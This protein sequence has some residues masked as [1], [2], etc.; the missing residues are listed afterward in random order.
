MHPVGC[1]YYLH[2]RCTVKQISDN[3]IYLLIKH[4]KS[5]LWRV[6]KRLSYREDARCLKIKAVTASQLPAQLSVGPDERCRTQNLFK[7]LLTSC[8]QSV[9]SRWGSPWHTI[10]IVVTFH[11][12]QEC[13]LICD[14][15]DKML[16]S[17]RVHTYSLSYLVY[18]MDQDYMINECRR[19]NLFKCSRI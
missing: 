18:D 3:E 11:P 5:F 16:T 17:L 14:A 4:I 9:C 10:T 13:L 6:A 2:Q 8:S 12:V 19:R 15:A 7:R 1:V